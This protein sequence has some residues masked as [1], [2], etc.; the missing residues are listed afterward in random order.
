MKRVLKAALVALMLVPS[1]GVAQDFDAGARAY[2]AGDFETALKELRPLAEQGN[3]WAQ[4]TLGRM[5][6]IGE[7]VLQDYSVAA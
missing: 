5:Y 1:S 3:A 6:I 2:E 7:G 4:N